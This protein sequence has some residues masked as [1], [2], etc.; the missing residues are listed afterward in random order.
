MTT[1]VVNLY[2]DK[3]NVYIGRKGK[4]KDG[5]FGNPVAIGSPCPICR[6]THTRAGDTIGCYRKYF[7]RRLEDDI[8][9]RAEVEALKGKVLGCFCKPKPC[10]GDVI[11][12]YL[13]A[14]DD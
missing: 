2:K 1:R 10:H 6:I 14:T 13:D 7:Y 9:F 4:G 11:K 3:Y 8:Q 12:E 5:Y